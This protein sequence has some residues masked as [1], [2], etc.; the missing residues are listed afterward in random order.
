M[1]NHA[2]SN[3]PADGSVSLKVRKGATGGLIIDTWYAGSDAF[4]VTIQTPDTSYGPFAAPANNAVDFRTNLANWL[5][6][7]TART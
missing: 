4:D 3:V 7:I 6:T 5:T 2:G 1:A